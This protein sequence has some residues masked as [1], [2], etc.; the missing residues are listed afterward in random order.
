MAMHV[1]NTPIAGNMHRDAR[2]QHPMGVYMLC[3]FL[4]GMEIT[5]DTAKLLA[6][7]KEHREEIT[8]LAEFS[9]PQE[10]WIGRGHRLA[11][12][13]RWF[14][15]DIVIDLCAAREILR[16]AGGKV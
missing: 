1:I 4:S 14:E 12:G 9:P 6:K 7:L 13:A 10:W 5:L 16:K 8:W 15:S 11:S 3:S 2:H